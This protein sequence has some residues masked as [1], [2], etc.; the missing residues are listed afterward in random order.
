MDEKNE[1]IQED[2]NE[3]ETYCKNYID[4]EILGGAS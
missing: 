2:I 3:I 4:T 1:N